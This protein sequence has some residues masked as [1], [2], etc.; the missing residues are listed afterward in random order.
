MGITGV[1]YVTC[2]TNV[3]YI[4]TNKINLVG[5]CEK[6]SRFSSKVGVKLDRASSGGNWS[7]SV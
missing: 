5:K 1:T 3:T 4:T 6:L 2:I 7:D